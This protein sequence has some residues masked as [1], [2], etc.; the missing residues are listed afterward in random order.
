MPGSQALRRAISSVSSR[1]CGLPV[2]RQDAILY[3]AAGVFAAGETLFAVTDD[4]REWGVAAVAPYVLAAICCEVVYRLRRARRLERDEGSET[5]VLRKVVMIAVLVFAVV[6]PLGLQ[7]TW[8]AEAKTCVTNPHGAQAQPEVPVIERAGDRFA[9][10]RDPYLS[11]PKTVGV[12]PSN[13]CKSVNDTSYFPYLPGMVVFGL[14]N[15]AKLPKELND[16]RLSL[17]LFTLIVVFVSLLLVPASSRRKWRALQ[18]L[19]VLPTGALPMVT[20]GDDLPV[21]AL[22]LLG[23]VLVQRRQ[24]VLAGVA[25]GVAGVLKWTAWPLILLTVLCV[26]DED[27]RPAVIRYCLAT[28]AVV[29]PV[30][31]AGAALGPHA[32]VEN[33]LMFPLGLTKVHSPAASPLPGQVLVQLL[34]AHKRVITAALVGFAFVVVIVV[35]IRRPPRTAYAAALFSGW[36]LAFATVVAPATRFGYFIY[37]ANMFVWAYLLHERWPLA[38]EE[39]A[40]PTRVTGQAEP[41][42]LAS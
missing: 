32:F 17:A 39:G 4:Y 15:A 34:P 38:R 37:P 27:D 7:V 36:A 22:L 14:A 31:G 20:G 42:Q 26:R 5:S 21:L 35:L 28:L 19:V 11:H 2:L 10:F 1:I 12:S 25:M 9:A 33:V 29:L 30:L 24:P 41:A 16:A 40:G 6:V 18:F 3:F 23:L 13:D 8:R